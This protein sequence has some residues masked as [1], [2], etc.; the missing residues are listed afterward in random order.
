MSAIVSSMNKLIYSSSK[1]LTVPYGPGTV[2]G[3]QDVAV[4]R[5]SDV[6]AQG[7]GM[8]ERPFV[9]WKEE[10]FRNV[11]PWRPSVPGEELNSLCLQMGSRLWRPLLGR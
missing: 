1:S 5:T 9:K 4:S 11:M 8:L 3:S 10:S 7:V 6:L 2:L